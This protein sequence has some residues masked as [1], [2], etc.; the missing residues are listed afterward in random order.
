MYLIVHLKINMKNKCSYFLNL[1]YPDPLAAFG[2]H[3][4]EFG[5]GE[6]KKNWISKCFG[7]IKVLFQKY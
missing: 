1:F 5:E 6:K 4:A 7:P 2:G 3:G